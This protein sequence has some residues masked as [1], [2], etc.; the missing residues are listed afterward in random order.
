[1]DPSSTLQREREAR[2]IEGVGAF[3][4]RDFE[5]LEQTMRP[6][7][8]M[9]L[10]GS[11]WLAGTYR[12]PEEVGRCILGLRHVLESSEDRVTFVH[13]ADHMT[14]DHD[15]RLHGPLHDL[16][17]SFSVAIGFDA[18]ERIVSVDVE[19]ADRGL[20]DHVLQ[21]ALLAFDASRFA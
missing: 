20:F 21:T 3:I 6:D 19:P 8:V 9:R 7:V 17:M 5:A 12:G 2:F 15:I 11:S 14:V 13:H 10:P 4:R 18:D 16:E 1:M